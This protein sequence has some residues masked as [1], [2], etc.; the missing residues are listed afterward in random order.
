MN[1]FSAA[2]Q[3]EHYINK[4]FRELMY[5]LRSK[6]YVDIHVVFCDLSILSGMTCFNGFHRLTARKAGTNKLIV[7]TFSNFYDDLNRELYIVDRDDTSNFSNRSF[8]KFEL[9]LN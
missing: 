2:A 7:V 9:S 1:K 3:D 5:F 6:G 4:K 8:N